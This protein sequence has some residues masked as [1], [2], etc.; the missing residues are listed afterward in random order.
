MHIENKQAR[1][2]CLRALEDK[3]FDELA[4]PRLEKSYDPHEMASMVASAA[5]SIHHSARRRPKM[6]QV[7]TKNTRN[8]NYDKYF[9]NLIN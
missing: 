5:A 1:P 2:L 3:N 6:S 9:N 7:I 4:D 8:Y